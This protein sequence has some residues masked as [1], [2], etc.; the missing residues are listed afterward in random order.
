V[1]LPGKREASCA[2]LAQ[3][4]PRSLNGTPRFAGPPFTAKALLPLAPAPPAAGGY[5]FGKEVPLSRIP[6]DVPRGSGV[7][8]STTMPEGG[9]RDFFFRSGHPLPSSESEATRERGLNR[10]D[11]RALARGGRRRFMPQR[12]CASSSEI[13]LNLP[14]SPP[15]PRP[16]RTRRLACLVG[17]RLGRRNT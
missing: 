16:G 7:W 3:G 10:G 11:P 4:R 9:K 8:P 5:R 6:A 13:G 17:R 2:A 14:R 15:P 1:R 12:P